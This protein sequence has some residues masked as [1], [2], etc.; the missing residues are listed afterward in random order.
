MTPAVKWLLIANAVVFFAQLIFLRVL[1]KESSDLLVSAFGLTPSWVLRGAI[2]QFATYMFLHG[3]FWHIA[4]NMFFLWMFGSP[5]EAEWGSR[6][7]LRFYFLA[8]AAGGLLNVLATM[9]YGGTTIGASG[10]IFG[11]MVAYAMLFPNNI[12]YLYCLI[13]I[14]AKNL[15]LIAAAIQLYNAILYTQPGA[16]GVAYFAHLGG[17]LFGYLYLKFG[18]RVRY[19]MPRLRFNFRNGEEK[20]VEDWDS[21]M[22]DEIDPIL[23]KIGR[24]GFGSLTRKERMTLKKGRGKKGRTK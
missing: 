2:W 9:G 14:R 7:F 4:M 24:E 15:V 6:S 3:G 11:I 5:I 17:A 19:S 20:K 12:I 13:P 10:A 22:C 16:G 23:D 1:G 8:G 18:D 21:F